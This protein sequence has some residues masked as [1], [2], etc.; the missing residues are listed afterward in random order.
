MR[1]RDWIFDLLLIGV[2]LLGAWLRTTGLDWDQGQHLHPDERFLTMVE[3]AL[4]VRECALPDTSLLNCPPE[5]RRWISLKTYFDT[6]RSPLNPYN[7]GYGFYVYGDLPIVLVNVVAEGMQALSEWTQT[8]LAERPDAWFAGWLQSVTGVSDW[9]GYGGVHLVGRQLSALADLLSIVLLYLIA[10]RVYNRKVALLAALFS[11]LAVLQIQQSHFFTVDTF[12][13]LFMYLA[14]WFAVRVWERAG[15]WQPETVTDWRSLLRAPVFRPSLGFG[16]AIGMAMASKINA[17]PLAV[18]LPLAFALALWP[19]RAEWQ[20]AADRSASAESVLWRVT[21]FL[22]VGGLAALLSFR[23]FQ[24]YAFVGLFSPNPQWLQNLADL[25]AQVSG[26]ADVPFALQWARRSHLFSFKNL[27]LWGLGLPL[28][29]VAWLGVVLMG[30][31][32]LRGDWR[33]HAL[34]WAWTVLYFGWQSMQFNPTMRYQL[35]IYPLLAL[36]AAWFVLESGRWLPERRRRRFWRATA[37]TL[38]LLAVFGAGLWAWMFTRIY[39]RDHTR[40]QATRWIYDTLPGALTARWQD[41]AGQQGQTPLPFPADGF[42]APDA[43]YTLTYVPRT[44]QRLDGFY[45]PHV[46]ARAAGPVQV[47]V[48]LLEVREGEEALLWSGALTAEPD[49]AG[50]QELAIGEVIDLWAGNTYRLAFNAVS[51][52]AVVSLCGPLTLQLLTEGNVVSQGLALPPES[53]QLPVG[54]TTSLTFAAADDGVIG[55]LRL[56]EVTL[57]ADAPPRQTLTLTVSAANGQ[58]AV[59]QQTADFSTPQHSLGDGWLLSLD[60]PLALRAGEPV[61][62][63]LQVDAGRLVLTGAAPANETTWDDGLPL[64]MDGFDGFGGLYYGDLNLELYWDDNEEKLARFQDI[65]DQADYIFITSNRQWGTIPR[66]PERYPL[67]TTYYRALLGCPP[68]EDLLRCYSLAEPGMYQG[69]LGFEL[70]QV[71]TSYPTL[72]LPNGRSWQINDQFAE[73]AFTVYDHPKVMIFRKS[74][75]YDPAQV[76]AVLGAVD[77]STVVHLTPRQAGRYKPLLLP[78]ETLA[79]QRTGGTWSDL[80][81]YESWQNRYP[82]LTVVW[83][84]VF[85]ALLGWLTYPLVRAALPGLADRGYPLARLVG[86]MLLAWFSWLAGS[87]GA[88]YTRPVIGASLA[89]LAGLG[90]ALG[91]QQRA[92]LREEWRTRRSYFLRVEALFFGLFL[93]DLFI[94]LGNPDLWHPSKGGERPMDFSYLNAVLKSTV[95][96]PYDPWFAG[97]YINYYYYGFVLVGTPVKLLGIVPSI[98]YNLLLPTWFALL[99]TAA[100]SLG[101]NLLA[102]WQPAASRL[103]A[104]VLRWAGG[105]AAL[106]GTL[107]LGNQG[108]PQMFWRGLQRIGAAGASLETASFFRRLGWAGRGLF[109]LMQGAA[110]PFIPGDFY[111]LPSRAIPAPGSIEPITEFPLFTFLY[112]DLHAHMIALPLTALTLAW[113]FSVVRTRARWPNRLFAGLGMMLGGLAVGALRPTNTWDY[114]TYLLFAAIGLGFARWQSGRR[115][116]FLPTLSPRLA[117][118]AYALAGSA[119]LWLIAKLAYWP[120]DRWFGSAYNEISRWNGPYTPISAYLTHWGLFLL[121]IVAWLAWETREWLDSIPLSSLEKL[122]PWR[123]LIE[124]VAAAA[125]AIWL[126]MWVMGVRIVWLAWPLAL[127]AGI[128]LIR[129]EQPAAKRMVLFMVGTASLLTLMVEVVVLVGDIG[130]MNTVFKFYLQAWM[131]FALS[132]GAAFAWTLAEYH[133]WLPRWRTLWESGLMLLLAGALSFSFLATLDKVRDRWVPSAPHSLDSMAYMPYAEYADY[134]VLM[135]LD[136]D[137]RAI[138]WMQEN[139]TGSPVIVEANT[140]EYHWGTRFTI[141]TGLPGVVGWNWHQRQQRALADP[142]QVERRVAEVRQFYDTPDAWAAYAFLQKYDVRYIVVGQLERAAYSAT[143]IAKFE[144]MDGWLWREV[145]RDGQTVIYEVR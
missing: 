128:L 33:R 26:D 101:W 44:D 75:D 63:H 32:I 118:V 127:W 107:L 61:Q 84:Y 18:M 74:A 129:A 3:S 90:L 73:E 104:R 4:D 72:Q 106:A 82:L 122:R 85:I 99:G 1:R 60:R 76:A 112:S 115:M 135:Q 48:L 141:Y 59:A 121:V 86:L 7:R 138:R 35:P 21:A 140:V 97:G 51:G 143:G 144:R 28:G 102:D 46:R 117:R 126:G 45:L 93:L 119:A 52:D 105:A 134:D 95:F 125:A 89:V 15:D 110:L 136:E 13:N 39:T 2:L 25:R 123:T 9:T 137:Y 62:I 38:G 16:V 24:P 36:M 145:Y 70:V 67:T 50:A 42:L 65:L 100:F 12:A 139:V 49:E 92:E 27:T 8:I 66:V 14:L 78:P 124:I 88:T 142:A 130:R 131:L 114:P 31:R 57:L 41:A 34:L 108:I 29:V 94:R 132:A 83:W 98:A 6:A 111:W 10:A 40:V 5:S 71:F 37:L 77:L 91:W 30:W 23:V 47:Q 81:S 11:S 116:D 113:T 20:A 79:V 56:D 64:R 43:P 22:A 96:P 17:A 55:G 58:S 54:E 87:L 103:S 133:R 68:A 109:D 120:F 19:R 69:E 53:C 80:F